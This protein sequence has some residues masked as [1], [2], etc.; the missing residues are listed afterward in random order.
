MRPLSRL[1]KKL[2]SIQSLE[3][4]ASIMFIQMKYIKNEAFL[5]ATASAYFSATGFGDLNITAEKM[6]A[7]KS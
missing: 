7:K 5:R 1:F 2:E 6:S 3:Q 4:Q